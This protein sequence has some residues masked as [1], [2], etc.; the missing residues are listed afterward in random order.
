[1]SQQHIVAV[2]LEEQRPEGIE[3]LTARFRFVSGEDAVYGAEGGFVLVLPKTCDEDAHHI[4]PWC[5]SASHILQTR[6]KRT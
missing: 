4:M 3:P 1:M 6:Q 2:P 5:L